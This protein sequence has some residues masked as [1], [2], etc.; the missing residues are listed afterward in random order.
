MAWF[1]LYILIAFLGIYSI[2]VLVVTAYLFTVMRSDII[3]C[4]LIAVYW[5]EALLERLFGGD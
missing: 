5:P 4:F 2:G 3:L 1:L